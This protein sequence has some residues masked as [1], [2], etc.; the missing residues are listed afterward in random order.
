[1]LWPQN[2]PVRIKYLFNTVLWF[3]VFLNTSANLCSKVWRTWSSRKKW[4]KVLN[5]RNYMY[6]MNNFSKN[7][8]PQVLVPIPLNWSL[9]TSVIY[10]NSDLTAIRSIFSFPETRYKDSL[11]CKYNCLKKFILKNSPIRLGCD[12]KSVKKN[13]LIRLMLNILHFVWQI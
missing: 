6:L 7:E 2:C 11:L 4:R 10:I 5:F 12:I 1:M 8:F 13:L 3:A 9:I